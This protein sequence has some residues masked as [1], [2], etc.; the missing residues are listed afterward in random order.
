MNWETWMR[1]FIV[2]KDCNVSWLAENTTIECPCEC[3]EE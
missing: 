2:C 3:D 1:E